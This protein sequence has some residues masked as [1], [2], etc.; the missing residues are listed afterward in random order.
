MKSVV[1]GVTTLFVN[2]QYNVENGLVVKYYS[3]GIQTI[4]VRRNGTLSYILGDHLGSTTIITSVSGTPI[5]GS[6][7]KPWGET[8]HTSGSIPTPY[9]YTGQREE[10]S[11]GLYFYNARWYDPYLNHFTQPDSIVPDPYNPQD[12]NR[13]AYVRNNP[14]R[15]NDPTGH[16]CSDP[17]DETGGC[18]GGGGT[19][20]SNYAA[21]FYRAFLNERYGWNI[22]DDFTEEELRVIRQTAYDIEAYIDG[23]TG[24]N[25]Q[26]W[27]LQA[28]G[29]TTIIHWDGDHADAM[30]YWTGS[31]IRLHQNWLTDGWGAEV[32]FAHEVGHVW[33]INTG[34]AASY[35]MNMDLGGSGVCLFCAPG[36]NVPQWDPGY[37]RTPSGDAYG[38]SGRNEYFAEAFSATIYNRGDAPIGVAA[39]ID[40]LISDPK[41]FLPWR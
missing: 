28:S 36:N 5:S 1:N 4:A 15:Y 7:Y 16:V 30:P 11:F 8:R 34:F 26:E 10:S 22:A 9:H 35:H 14:I 17:E 27:M 32:V 18:E 13:Y 41:Y 39:W 25:G 19:L 12:W 31:R 6:L 3:A 37:H 29:N 20:S 2:A 24:G 23:L 38:N 21:N 40:T 33:D